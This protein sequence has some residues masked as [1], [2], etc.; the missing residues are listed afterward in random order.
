MSNRS[1]RGKRASGKDYDA[2]KRP[3]PRH[4]S[5]PCGCAFR[6]FRNRLVAFRSEESFEGDS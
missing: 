5:K 2:A 4:M 1:G 6:I 3:S